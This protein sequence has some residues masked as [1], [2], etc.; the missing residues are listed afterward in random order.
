VDINLN[1]EEK[2]IVFVK[3]FLKGKIIPVDFV[4]VV[5]QIALF[6]TQEKRENKVKI[7]NPDCEYEVGD[8]IYKEYPG[9][10]PIGSKKYIEMDKGVVLKVVDVRTRFGLDEIRL[11]YEGTS[12]FRKYTDYLDRQKIGLFLPH[13]QKKPCV[14][15]IFLDVKKD[16]R[17]QQDPLIEKDFT[18]LKKKLISML[19]KETDMALVG[20]KILLTENLK[21]IGA[22][23]FDKIREFLTENKKSERTEFLVEHFLK[24]KPDNKEFDAYCFAL[25][26]LMKRD[27]KIDFQQTIQKGWGKWNLISVI[28]YLKKES[29]VSEE[30]PLLE[31][32]MFDDKKNLNQRRKKF[33]DGIFDNQNFRYYLT[34]REIASGALKIKSGLYDFGDAIEIE[35]IDENTKKSSI[36]YYYQ[37][38]NLILGFNDVF[39]SYKAMQGMT[40]VFEQIEENQF[41]FNIRTT[42]K[43]TIADTIVY[44]PERK[45]FLVKED[46]VA[47]PVFVNKAMFLEPDVFKKLEEKVD[48]FKKIET[49][50]KLVHKIFL[51]FGIKDKNYEIHVF[52]LYHILDLIYPV[53]L[54]LIE[55]IIL[56]NPEFILSEKVTGIIY[57]DSDAVVEIEEEERQRRE[58]VIKEAIKRREKIRLEKMEEEL[59]IKEEIRLKREEHRKK[60]ESEMW[61]KEK[62]REE[63]DKK[64]ILEK[65]RDVR[66][67][68]EDEVS[69]PK[70]KDAEYPRKSFVSGPLE[71]FIVE[72]GG[73]KKDHTK[74]DRK[75]VEDEKPLKA[76]KRVEKKPKEEKLDI[77]EIKKDIKLE[78][79][80]E[81]VLEKK[82]TEK[83]KKEEVAYEDNGGFGGV[84]ASK[85]DEVVKKEDKKKSKKGSKK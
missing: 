13:K 3:E 49:L 71:D 10:I 32:V 30:N 16:P 77:D 34:Q 82:K 25:N 67:P 66:K 80:K 60:R 26:F 69:R 2:D 11:S 14:P 55:S 20:E 33:E 56:S 75:R 54:K 1:I 35:A 17:K 37:D 7:Y 68:A 50:N 65:R 79:L 70:R 73:V 6:K 9:K 21:E 8:L 85:L 51:D 64:K 40:M 47:S 44:D 5:Y 62:M 48:E 15:V 4:D 39:E 59:K 46:K 74:K 81:K 43:G 19:Q 72:K 76:K 42:K 61:M 41:S 24:I 53:N 18:V 57:L 31:T 63:K 52:R 27:Y 22:D 38:V 29:L 12:A 83:K 28:Y 78:E 84:L 36:L 58:L 45:I 23:V